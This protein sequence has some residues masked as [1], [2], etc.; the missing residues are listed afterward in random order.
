MRAARRRRSVSARAATVVAGTVFVLSA[1]VAPAAAETCSYDAGTRA[2]TATIDPAGDATLQVTASGE[3]WF[4]ATPS[5]CGAATA[6]N[7]DS[8]SIAG[9]PGT[10]E[11][12]TIDQSQAFLGPGFSAESNFPEI[13]TTVALG[14]TA[15]ALIVVGTSGNDSIAMGANGL[16]LN[17]DGDVDVTFAPLPAAVEIRGGAGANALTGRGGWGAGLAYAGEITLI[18]GNF[19]DELNGGNGSD[20]LTGGD[21]ADVLNGNAGDD[22]LEG[23]ADD[24]RLSGGDG[25]DFLLGGAGADRFLGGFGNDFLNAFDGEADLQINGGPDVDVAFYDPGLDPVPSASESNV[26]GPP[27][28]SCEHDATARTVTARLEPGTDATL[29]VSATG[30][31]LFG[32]VPTPCGTA[33]STNTDSVQVNGAAGIPES[34]TLDLSD[35]PFGPGFSAESNFP[36]IEANVALGDT[37]DDFVVIGTA[38]GDTLTAGALGVSLN[39]DGDLDVTFSP[40]PARIELRAEGGVN[41]LTGRGGFGAGLAY[42]GSAVLL[43]GDLGDALDGGNGDDV[44]VG[45]LGND[46]MNGSGGNDEMTGGGGGDSLTGSDGADTIVGGAGADSMLGGIGDDVIE[47]D[48]D[49]AD[50]QIHGGSGVDTAYVDAGIDPATVAVETVVPR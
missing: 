4:G 27:A 26:P 15:D 12:L 35:S 23:N 30:Q 2:V 49:E 18:A 5:A 43:G 17:S 14:D 20:Q 16:S 34:L 31:I 42:P 41:L 50:T 37:S 6:A 8:I 13:E 48:D 32:V 25:K 24:D 3:I 45:G 21:G 10:T 7:A 38:G 22:R 44:I 19:G 39:A 36:E 29:D 1:N 47:A 40:L 28:E 33:T 46:V 11:T 9:A